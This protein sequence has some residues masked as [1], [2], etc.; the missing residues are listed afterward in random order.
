MKGY[1][2][3]LMCLPV[4]VNAQLV[5]HTGMDN[6]TPPSPF[7]THTG[8]FSLPSN[9]TGTPSGESTVAVTGTNLT[10]DMV[11]TAGSGTEVSNNG[12]TWANTATFTNVSGTASGTLHLRTLGANSPGNISDH[13]SGTSTGANTDNTAIYTTTTL[14]IPTMSYS[15]NPITGVN[16]VAGTAGSG[17]SGN[18]TFANL[19][20]TLLA[21]PTTNMEISGNGGSTWGASY[22]MAQNATSPFAYQVR[23]KASNSAGSLTG[24]VT[25]HTNGASDLVVNASGTVTSPSN[26]ADTARF[27]FSLTSKT[28]PSGF[29]NVFGDPSTGIRTGSNGTST[30]SISSVATANWSTVSGASAGDGIG[31]TGSTV[32]G[33]PDNVLQNGWYTYSGSSN[34]ADST[35]QTLS[36]ANFLISGSSISN[37]NTYHIEFTACLD[38]S[39]FALTCNNYYYALGTPTTAYRTTTTLNANNNT[40]T[41]ITLSGVQPNASG[42]IK[43]YLF[44]VSGQEL[45]ILS[46][47]S[48]WKE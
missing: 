14:A 11:W 9:F 21:T 42:Q 26:A 23:S 19:A 8:S 1:L 12:S 16:S 38:G 34:I 36:K 45:G 31:K 18:L 3:L 15:P 20:S 37:S 25:F 39:R 4:L 46:G 44:T 5:K 48:I 35:S 41:K 13:V 47:I 43:I 2:L 17:V 24:T 27:M 10:A 7:V 29:V 30:I 40:T 28:A 6:G 32:T 22:T 33:F